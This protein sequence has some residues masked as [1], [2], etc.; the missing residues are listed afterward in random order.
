MLAGKNQLPFY[1]GTL[2]VLVL[3]AGGA[4]AQQTVYK[5]VDE[6]GVVHFGESAPAGVEAER[7]TTTA[8]PQ[9]VPSPAPSR[10][11]R[12]ARPPEAPQSEKPPV[13]AKPVAATTPVADMTLAELDQRCED[14]RE[15]KIAP[16]RAA[17]IERCKAQP[18]NDPAFCERFN[19][20]FGE[21]GRNVNGTIRPRMFDD[22]PECVEALQE[23]H[24]RRN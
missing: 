1:L 13:A 17:E 4:T 6:D 18:R 24:R 8:A 7:I 12:V 23:R 15:A 22:L 3:L 21:G 20:D 2:F 19:A 10:A 5:W 11:A 9:T 14:A 16:M